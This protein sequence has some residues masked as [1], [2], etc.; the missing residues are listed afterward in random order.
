MGIRQDMSTKTGTIFSEDIL[1]IEI[2]GPREDYLT[3]IDVPGIFRNHAEGI[4]TK[5]DI[6]LVNS[7][8]R[9]Y[10]KDQRTIILAVLPSNVDIA[11][12]EII[13]LAEEHDKLGERT[14]G[15]LTKPDLVTESTAKASVCNLVC[16]NRRPLALG[17]YLVRN[18]GADDA[19]N[20]EQDELET[21]F[22]QEP[23]SALPP[24]RVGVCAFEKAA[25]NTTG[26]NHSSR[27]S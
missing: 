4:T 16:G 10:I 26:S 9:K 24:D 14:L 21:M 13:E 15:V 27:V 22:Q 2:Y 25:G 23:W 6:L 5:K 8:V 1:K 19:E 7:L 11:T 18:R 12:Q 3:V 20:V 17:Y